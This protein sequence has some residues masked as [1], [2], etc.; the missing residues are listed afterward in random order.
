MKYWLRCF[1]VLIL[2]GT[3]LGQ[4]D[5]EFSELFVKAES[6][7]AYAQNNLGG[8]YYIGNRVDQNYV[9]AFK[10]FRK[11]ARQGYPP[12]QKKLG[13]LYEEG[14]GVK[15]NFEKAFKW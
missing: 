7:D 14:F 5:W 9:E 13:M 3:L 8:I 11:S 4:S 6:G 1:I 12:A 15:Q 10:W 2:N